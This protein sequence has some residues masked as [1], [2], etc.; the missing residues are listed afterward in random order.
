MKNQQI[1]A[2]KSA[3][4]KIIFL[5]VC[6]IS[7]TNLSAEC[8]VNECSDKMDQVYLGSSVKLVE[9]VSQSILDRCITSKRKPLKLRQSHFMYDR[10]RQLRPD[11]ALSQNQLTVVLNENA[12]PCE[13]TTIL[14]MPSNVR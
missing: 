4:Y 12:D 11:A 7:S 6:S 1:A 2:K 13:I 9:S 8:K 14:L 3:F 5:I 10:I